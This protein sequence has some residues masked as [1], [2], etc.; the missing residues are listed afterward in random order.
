V[1]AFPD[2]TWEVQ[3]TVANGE[4]V[5]ARV[6]ERGTFKNPYEYR[7]GAVLA[8]TGKS[9]AAHYAIFVKVNDKGLFTEYHLYEDASWSKQV[10]LDIKQGEIRMQE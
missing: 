5:A 8:P 2:F 6:I 4:W 10:G 1:T 3:A 7:P 9:Y